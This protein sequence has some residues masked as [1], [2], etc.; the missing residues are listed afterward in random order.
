LNVMLFLVISLIVHSIPLPFNP[1]LFRPRRLLRWL[2]FRLVWGT[3]AW[4][5]ICLIMGMTLPW[6]YL[7]LATSF[8]LVLLLS[9]VGLRTMGF[10]RIRPTQEASMALVCIGIIVLITVPVYSGVVAWTSDVANAQVFDEMIVETDQPLFNSTIP[11]GQVRLVTQEYALYV[12]QQHIAPLGSEWIPAAAHITTRN[13]RLVWVVI[14]VSTNTLAANYIKALVVVDAN[15][16]QGIEPEIIEDINLPL[17]E[18]LFWDKNIQ[19]SN[20][21][22]DMTSAFQY[23][24]PTWDPLG[25]LAYVQTRTPI[26]FGFVER[27]IGPIVY[28]ENGSIITYE[29]IEETP[30][31]ITQAYSEEWLERQ[32]SRWG[33]YRREDGFDLFAGG[34]LWTIAPSSDRLEMTEDTRYIIN[35]DSNRV[36]ALVAVHPVTSSRTLAGIFRATRTTVYYHDLSSYSYVSGDAAAENVVG[37]LTPPA[38][39]FYFASMPLLYPVEISPSQTAWTWYAPIFWVKG[40]WDDSDYYV[41][42]DMNLHALA[43]VDASNINRYYIQETGGTI[44]GEDLVRTTREGFVALFGATLSDIFELTANVTSTTAFV[45][46]GDT[47]VLLGTDNSSYLF[48]EG[49]KMWMNHTDWYALLTIEPGESFTATIQIVGEQHRIVAFVKN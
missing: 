37:Q 2:P 29:T 47:H 11:D 14:V 4:V 20:Y 38:S 30:D 34:F 43:L 39:G 8:G 16:P 42:T 24:Y 1:E 6:A 25:V 44:W 33:G 49:A 18:S 45:D 35:P 3:V 10:H 12:A 7:T 5:F 48:I 40:Y 31:W 9:G 36:E 32:V 13:G 41:F 17:G 22:N 19:F 15:D 28:F 21:L 26:D 46:N 27:A 23:A